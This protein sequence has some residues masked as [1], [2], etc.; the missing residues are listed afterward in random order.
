MFTFKIKETADHPGI[1][2]QY[3]T[4]NGYNP[5]VPLRWNDLEQFNSIKNPPRSGD[6]YSIATRLPSGKSGRHVIYTIWQRQL[7]ESPEA[8]YLCN[9]VIF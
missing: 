1:W 8:F 5:L 2:T 4:K 6:V 7:P 9:D 3:V